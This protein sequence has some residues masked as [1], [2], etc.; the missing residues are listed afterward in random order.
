ME[1]NGE[2]S[3]EKALSGFRLH[4]FELRNWGTFDKWIWHIAPSGHNALLT[5]DIGSGKSTIVDAITTLL[6]RQDRIIY[7]KAAGAESRERTIY[8]YIR[9]AYK[10]EKAGSSG[11]SQDVY[12]RDE[13]TYSVILGQFRN[14][15]FGDHVTLAQ[16]FWLRNSKPDKFFVIAHRHIGIKED[17]SEFGTDIFR[18]KKRLKHAP[19]IEVFDSFT[20]Y[21]NRFRQLFGIKQAGA[22]DLFYQ[23]VSMKSVGNLTDFV[24]DQMLGKTNIQDEINDLVRSYEE[25]TKAHDA[26]QRA[27]H[28]KEMLEPLMQNISQFTVIKEEIAQYVSSLSEIPKWFS[29]RRIGGLRRKLQEQ[30]DDF[31]RNEHDLAVLDADLTKDRNTLRQLEN[32]RDR[33]E[34]SRMLDEIRINLEHLESERMRKEKNARRYASF[35]KALD[36]PELIDEDRFYKNLKEARESLVSTQEELTAISSEQR[37]LHVELDRLTSEA[38]ELKREIDSLQ[39]RQTQIPER[40]IALRHQICN[41]LDLDESEIPYAGELIRVKDDE[42]SWEGAIERRLH[43]FGLSMLVPDRHYKAIS[44]YVN[45]HHPHGRLVYLR[46]FDRNRRDDI[47]VKSNSLFHKVQIKSDSEFSGW[48]EAEVCDRYNYVCCSTLDEFHR[49]P[50]ALTKEGQIK[51]GKVKHEKNDLRNV[52]DRKHYVL[53]WSNAEKI[54]EYRKELERKSTLIKGSEAALES[55]T[56]RET[57][58]SEKKDHLRDLTQFDDFTEVDFKKTVVEIQSL[59]ERKSTL[60]ASSHELKTVQQEIEKLEKT[61]KDKDDRK[62]NK[63][64]EKGKLEVRISENALLLKRNLEDVMGQSDE[65]INLSEDIF[66]DLRAVLTRWNAIKLPLIEFSPIT[67]GL[68]AGIKET[69]ALDALDADEKRILEKVNNPGGL[70]DK[71]KNAQKTLEKDIVLVMQRYREQNQAETTDVDAS[72]ESIPD[73]EAIYEKLVVDDIPR[74]EGRFKTLLKEGAINGILVFQNQLDG[75]DKEIARKIADINKHLV[76]IPYNAGTYIAITQDAVPEKDIAEFKNDL[77]ACLANIY[78]EADRYNEEKFHQVKKILDRF[79]GETD[80]DKRWTERVTDVRQW[81]T[82]GASERYEEDNKEKEYYSDS[83]GKS[84]GQK[85]KLAYTILASAIA[86]QFGLSWDEARSR[87]FRFVVIDEAFGRGSD[88]ST[89]YGLRLFRKLNLQL[90]IV[91]PLQKINI[92]EDYINAVHFVS[93]PTG[94]ASKVRNITKQEY[95][96]EK[97][98]YF[99]NL[100]HV[101]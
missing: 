98:Q 19:G 45:D 13:N 51:S 101:K 76:D 86:F 81:Y 89:R 43:D 22:L 55:L 58:L 91:T 67:L 23:T 78:G 68:V 70:L 83:S 4:K 84:G 72:I 42:R 54:K 64:G 40:N 96:K 8:S 24:R 50:Y 2:N 31:E 37:Q 1:S 53:G 97:Q 47:E 57:A 39:K 48:L 26:A 10:N 75:F 95:V 46:V 61:I 93:N 14:A 92:I 6:V 34:V 73:F 65:R 85:E 7:N 28:Q 11:K 80:E 9:G 77:K 38:Q 79:K 69:S 27:R 87:S 41:A 74:H 59:R 49:E 25:L 15:H 32:Q 29:I 52:N 17:F 62:G 88:E 3:S 71:R 5:G 36:L 35:C 99:A 20:D 63:R 30:V 21:A 100:E 82:F 56:L 44:R 94:Q 12:L 16:V 18:L 66:A 90:L 33:M 60:E